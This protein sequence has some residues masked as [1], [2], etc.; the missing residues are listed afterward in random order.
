MPGVIVSPR[1][2]ATRFSVHF[3]NDERD[4]DRALETLSGMLR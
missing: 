4:V 2:G 1:V 3:F